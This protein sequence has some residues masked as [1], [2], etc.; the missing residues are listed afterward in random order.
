[1]LVILVFVFRTEQ[2]A[3]AHCAWPWPDEQ[4]VPLCPDTEPVKEIVYMSIPTF[5][6]TC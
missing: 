1:M 2:G 6:E 4:L 3:V 5:M